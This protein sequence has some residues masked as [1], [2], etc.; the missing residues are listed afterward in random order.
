MS[1]G[2]ESR[3]VYDGPEARLGGALEL[4]LSGG[5]GHGNSSR[6]VLE[7]AGGA[8]NLMESSP[9]AERQ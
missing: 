5:S 9:W 1:R 8:E 4:L 3:S 6:E 7:Q 2:P